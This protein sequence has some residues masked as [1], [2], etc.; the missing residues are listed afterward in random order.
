ML[1]NFKVLEGELNIQTKVTGAC[2]LDPCE[3]MLGF[4]PVVELCGSC[5]Q[6]LWYRLERHTLLPCCWRRLTFL[7]LIAMNNHRNATT[8]TLKTSDHVKLNTCVMDKTIRVMVFCAG[9]IHG[10]QDIAFPYQSE[11]KV[12]GGEIKANLRGLKNKSGTTRPVDITDS[13][14]LDK[15]SY[16][17]NIE[18]TYALTNKVI[19]NPKGGQ[20]RRKE[21]SKTL[22]RSQV[23]PMLTRY[24][25]PR[26]PLA[27]SEMELC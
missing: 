18:F 16:Q 1:G 6:Q 9:D 2:L 13:L 7:P 26:P 5:F 21:V 11:L 24:Q 4:V 12:N 3:H 27:S 23:V 8:I 22:P 25:S 14:R 20:D 19:T 10:L 17:N 15:A